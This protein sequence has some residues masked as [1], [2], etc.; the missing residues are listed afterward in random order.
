MEGSLVSGGLP[1]KGGWK[2]EGLNFRGSEMEGF[3]IKKKEV[4]TGG[5]AGGRNEFRMGGD[6]WRQMELAKRAHLIY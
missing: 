6:R 2:Y 4:R 5:R 1:C 3:Q